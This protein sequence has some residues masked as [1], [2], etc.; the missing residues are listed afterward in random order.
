MRIVDR[1][2]E[3]KKA[4]WFAVAGV[5]VTVVMCIWLFATNSGMIARLGFMDNFDKTVSQDISVYGS[6]GN[7]L[8]RYEGN[9]DVARLDGH[10]TV[11]N[12]DN[13][14]RIDF[15][16]DVVVIIDEPLPPAQEAD[17]E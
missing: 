12:L 8:R 11:I 5:I 13:Q 2:K 3:S 15:Y 16:G 4:K 7:I 1:F 6:D 17:G 9:Y 10:Y 14:T